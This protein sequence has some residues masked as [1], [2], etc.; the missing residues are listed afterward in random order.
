MTIIAKVEMKGSLLDQVKIEL[1]KQLYPK[2]LKGALFEMGL[3]ILN[4]AKA[5]APFDTGELR[6][7]GQV[8]PPKDT[9]RGPE[10]LLAFLAKHALPQ[11]ERTDWRHEKGEAKYLENT[12]KDYSGKYIEELADLTELNVK[13]GDVAVPSSPKGKGSEG[14]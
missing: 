1:Y 3:K 9:Y 10:V 14:G 7:S 6:R 4:D 5:R 12:L 2:A 11:H 8:E 13:T